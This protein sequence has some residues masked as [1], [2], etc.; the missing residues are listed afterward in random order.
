MRAWYPLIAT[1]NLG[2]TSVACG[3]PANPAAEIFAVMQKSALEWNRGD[4]AAFAHSYKNSSDILFIGHSV[5]HGY[6]QMLAAYREHYANRAQMGRLSFSQLAMQP[7][8]ERFATVTGNY[9]LRRGKVGGGD[10]DGYFLLVFEKTTRGWKIVRD[11]STALPR[12][13]P[14]APGH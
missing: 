1:L 11:D 10:A 14:C 3:A 5:S 4:I 7:L 6:A 13:G 8:D 12:S 2:L 9:H